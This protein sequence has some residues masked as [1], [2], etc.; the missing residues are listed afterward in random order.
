MRIPFAKLEGVEVN[1]PG[2]SGN[3]MNAGIDFYIPTKGSILEFNPGMKDDGAWITY[4][5]K[6][7]FCTGYEKLSVN[8][9]LQAAVYALVHELVVEFHQTHRHKRSHQSPL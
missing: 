3:T 9:R 6:E 2:K 1:Q 7:E 8:N 4:L 5:F